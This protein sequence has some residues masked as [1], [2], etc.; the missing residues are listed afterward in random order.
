LQN[1]LPKLG[2]NWF[3][4]LFV[5]GL[6]LASKKPGQGRLRVFLLLMLATLIIVQA[7][8]RTHLMQ[9]QPEVSS[10][11][12]LVLAVPLVFVYAAALCVEMI[13][14]V[15]VAFPEMRVLIN[16][17]IWAIFSLPLLVAMLP[18]RPAPLS[19]PPYYPFIIQHAASLMTDD[20]MVMTDMPWAMAWYGH[21]R[22][23]SLTLSMPDFVT[24]S[25]LKFVNAVYLTEITTDARF[26][27]RLVKGEDKV[28]CRLILEIQVLQRVPAKFPL[29]NVWTDVGMPSQLFIADFERWK[30]GAK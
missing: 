14:Q 8:G 30:G 2:G 15:P 7:L 24:I 13:S 12:L 6:L 5:A 10:E 3:S 17:G 21:R 18:P 1:D 9:S 29:K 25:D 16:A 4:G 23:V 19:Y 22:A 27:S 11:N 28:W 20:D 26:L